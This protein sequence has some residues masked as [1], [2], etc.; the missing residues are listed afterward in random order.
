MTFGQWI[1]EL[2]AQHE[3][4]QERLA[5]RVGCATSTLRSFEQG[6]RRPSREMSER[7]AD[8]LEIPSEQRNEFLRAARQL[9]D[10]SS[11]KRQKN[12]APLSANQLLHATPPRSKWPPTS[13]TFIGRQAEQDALQEML[14]EDNDEI[15]VKKVEF[16]ASLADFYRETLSKQP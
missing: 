3:L 5:E 16:T 12:E 11:K 2:R 14:L 15:S 8:V 1:K 10:A 13:G 9:V 4:T 7:I 6:A